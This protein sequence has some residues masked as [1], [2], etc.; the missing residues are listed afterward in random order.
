M[1]GM[2]QEIIR[3]CEGAKRQE[4]AGR[5]RTCR[6]WQNGVRGV[7]ISFEYEAQMHKSIPLAEGSWL[8]ICTL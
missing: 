2:S 7:R 1:L 3:T 4:A 8:L 5:D 6:T